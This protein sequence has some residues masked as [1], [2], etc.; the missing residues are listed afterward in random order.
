MKRFSPLVILLLVAVYFSITG[1]QC[2][3]AEL[4]TAKL[5]MQQQQWDKAEVSL[6]NEVAKNQ[7]N[8]E[9]WYLLG[10]VRLEM[11]NYQG[12]NEAYTKALALS[13][14][15]RKEIGN[16]RLA[17]WGDLYNDGI[18][19]Y[20]KGKD[21]PS[22]YDKAI[23]S[24]GT[25]LSLV[26]DSASTYYVLAL[27][28]YTKKDY[29]NAEPNLKTA[30]TKKPDYAEAADLLGQVCLARASEKTLA[31][32][33]VGATTEYEKAAAAFE[34]AYKANPQKPDYILS[35]IEAYD[36]ADQSDKAM[37]L[38][39]D[40]VASDPTNR[41]YRY[42]YGVFL[43][44]QDKF[45][46]GIEQF[47]NV[48][49][50]V[51]DSVDAIYIDATYNLGVSYLNWGVAMKKESDRKAEADRKKIG[52]NAKVDLSY[53]EKFRAALPYLE[54]SSK[55]REDNAVLWQQLGKVY[56]NLN[57]V[58]KSKEAFDE[59]DRIMSNN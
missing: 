19:S 20:N 4:T 23:E 12:M 47:S 50:P 51:P 37:A 35:L 31:K 29:D 59:A 44:K 42:V 21:D 16:N 33:T 58:G 24:F 8:E 1:F 40:A 10:Q 48:G 2:G 46:D 53:K 54:K 22:N 36:K 5:A 38:T 57:M 7:Q 9:A 15:H 28:H 32:D 25:A 18:A 17:V 56:A 52:R 45:E 6:M 26:P 11:K 39:R 55:L 3:S 34:K 49:Q 27:A 14:D 13:D 43:L 30:L 41:T